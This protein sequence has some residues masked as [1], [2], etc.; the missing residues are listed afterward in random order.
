MNNAQGTTTVTL[1]TSYGL[2]RTLIFAKDLKQGDF[3]INRGNVCVVDNIS[4]GVGVSVSA[5][6]A[7][8]KV[9]S[10]KH[11]TLSATVRKIQP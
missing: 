3:F 9:K 2:Q 8:T 6:Q 5:R 10:N 4:V 11:C 1:P 7:F